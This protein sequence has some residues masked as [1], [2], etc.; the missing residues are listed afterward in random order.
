MR[1]WL[2][3]VERREIQ[4]ALSNTFE[5]IGTYPGN[6]CLWFSSRIRLKHLLNSI[7]LMMN[8]LEWQDFVRLGSNPICST[9]NSISFIHTF[10]MM[11]ASREEFYSLQS[12]L[13]H[14]QNGNNRTKH[15]YT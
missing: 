5:L 8:T 12:P 9:N 4:K 10:L 6:R 14:T 2:D 1:R 15:R 11:T 13:F 7:K 3:P